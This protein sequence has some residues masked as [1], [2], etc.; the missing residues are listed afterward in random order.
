MCAIKLVVYMTTAFP[1]IYVYNLKT[2]QAYY[3]FIHEIW[4]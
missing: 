1:G 3:Y 4:R 2:F